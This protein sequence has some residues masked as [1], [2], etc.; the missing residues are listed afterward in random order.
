M[1][2]H[3]H[4]M[5]INTLVMLS[6]QRKACKTIDLET[7]NIQFPPPP[8]PPPRM[9]RATTN[10]HACVPP[11]SSAVVLFLACSFSSATTSS[12]LLASCCQK[13]DG[14]SCN[15]LVV[16]VNVV[17]I[18]HFSPAMGPAY[19]LYTSLSLMMILQQKQLLP[20]MTNSSAPRS[21]K[22]QKWN[23]AIKAV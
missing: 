16:V 8:P 17:L 14:A 7:W 10:I 19:F 12:P 2:M 13:R 4:I 9:A 15:I 3:L 6:V 21:K 1:Q 22:K 11:V 23:G 20:K 5:E 18:P